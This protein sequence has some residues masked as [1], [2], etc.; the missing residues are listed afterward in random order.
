[1]GAPRTAEHGGHSVTAISF[2]CAQTHRN[3]NRI[4]FGRIPSRHPSPHP[5]FIMLRSICYKLRFN[6]K[7]RTPNAN[8]GL[9]SLLKTII[10]L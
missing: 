1:M 9:P 5:D 6:D 2:P 7:L 3:A 4:P 10:D 8:C